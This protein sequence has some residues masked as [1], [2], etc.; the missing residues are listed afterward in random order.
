MGV[1]GECGRSEPALLSGERLGDVTP[2]D[3]L[4]DTGG[5]G[6][7]WDRASDLS[8]AEVTAKD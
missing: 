2:G 8:D 3:E 1:M 6:R 4:D 5:G 7:S